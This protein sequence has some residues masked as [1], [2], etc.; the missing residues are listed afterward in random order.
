MEPND[1]IEEFEN[2]VIQAIEPEPLTKK[3][4]CSAHTPQN[5]CIEDGLKIRLLQNLIGR[6]RSVS[7][8]MLYKLYFLIYS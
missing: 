2:N 1:E 5:L 8:S 7:T 4:R 3:V 6:I